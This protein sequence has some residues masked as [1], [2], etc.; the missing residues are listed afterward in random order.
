MLLSQKCWWAFVQKE[1]VKVLTHQITLPM[2]LVSKKVLI[3]QK[4]LINQTSLIFQKKLIDQKFLAF[5]IVSAYQTALKSQMKLV[6]QTVLRRVTIEYQM[7]FTFRM[8]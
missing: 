2:R 4:E 6:N 7:V 5:R 1:E 8:C 3:Y